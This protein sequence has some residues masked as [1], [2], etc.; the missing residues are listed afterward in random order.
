M[1]LIG[2]TACGKL[3]DYRQAVIH[4]GGE[5]RILERSMTPVDALNGIGGLL[6]PGGGDVEPA[7]YGEE[8]HPSLVDV[9]PLRDEFEIALV[10]EARS[11]NLPIFAICRGLQVLN[12]A[13]GG[14][15]VQD[16]PSQVPGALE[17]RLAVPPHEAF[18]LA[19]EVWIDKD[20]KLARLMSERL[21]GADTCDVNSRHHQ[22]VK[23]V[24][25]NFYVSATAPDGVIEAIEDPSAP[26]CLAVQWHPENFWRTGEFRPL[27]ETFVEAAQM[28]ENPKT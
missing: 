22:A 16:I 24:A 27:F 9:E 11:R 3:E 10:R 6:L 23:Q 12:V 26:F 21:G 20:T 4:V 17:H 25:P 28:S 18:A 8:P 7:R 14:T 15:L 13:F 5:V 2:I 1:A 19:H